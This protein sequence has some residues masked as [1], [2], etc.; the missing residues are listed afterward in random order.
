LNIAV[1]EDEAA[2]T[3]LLCDILNHSDIQNTYTVFTDADSFLASYEYG[4]YDL[5][6]MDI[7]MKDSMT[8]IEAVSIIRETDADIPVAFITT[9]TEHALE[10]YRLSAIGYIEKPVSAAELSNILHLAM[11]KK[12]DAPSLYVKRNKSMERLALSDIMYIEQRARQI[13]I[14]L[15]KMRKSA[16]MRSFQ[17]FQISCPL[18][19]FSA[20]QKLRG[21]PVVCH[22]H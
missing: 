1:C 14:H 11:L 19:C 7:Y 20:A 3:V 12:S 5:L 9:S 10:S 16:A 2:E 21:K 15:K 22:T 17:S 13:F 18:S 6:L 4:K 8:G